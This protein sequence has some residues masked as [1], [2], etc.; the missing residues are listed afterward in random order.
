MENIIDDLQWRG[1]IAQSTD[2]AALREAFENGQVTYYTGFDPTAAS[3]HVGHLVQVITMRR[4]QQAGHRPI[5]LVGG[6]TGL[7]GDPRE[8]TERSMND[9]E[10]VAGWVDK[11]RGQLK[12]FFETEGENGAIFV[13]NLDWTKDLSAIDLLRDVGKHFRLGTMLSKD[14]VA[15]RLNS[16]EGISFTEFSYQL[17]QGNDFRELLRRYGCTLQSAGNDQWGNIVAGIDLIRKTDGTPVHGLTTKLI[18]KSDGTKMGKSEGGAVWL[19]PNLFSP[20][21]F[22]Q[23]WLNTADDDVINYLKVFTFRT[24]EEIEALA[25]EVKEN[26]GARA[27]QRALAGDLTTLV[28]GQKATDGAIAAAKAIFGGGDLT[29]L[30][31]QTLNGVAKELPTA[32]AAPGTSVVDAAVN[33]GLVKSKS[34]ARRAI[35]EGGLYLNNVKVTDADATLEPKDFLA[36]RFAIVRRGKKTLGV[37]TQEA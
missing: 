26:P 3:L 9:A 25:Q 18:T 16:D 6:A 10:V 28:H 11:I 7:I 23:Y 36:N 34:E 31:E 24:R 20:Y 35:Q 33:I 8:T 15:R 32:N 37:A 14:I 29:E 2:E 19:D 17:L 13:N 22:Y 21:A 30:D 27:A 4:L 12:P 1:L 5:V